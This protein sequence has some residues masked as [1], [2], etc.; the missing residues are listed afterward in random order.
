CQ[1]RRGAH[2]QLLGHAHFVEAVGIFLCED[3][4]VRIFGEVGAQADNARLGFGYPCQRMAERRRLHAHVLRKERR[5]KAGLALAGLGGATRFEPGQPHCGF[6]S[7]RASRASAHSCGATGRKWLISRC[8]RKGT[9]VPMRVSQMM[10]RGCGPANARAT[11]KAAVRVSM[12][13]PS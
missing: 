10:T 7:S 5:G 13:L 3:V 9:P 12:S 1:T 2:Q 6:P 8:W 11:S 4:Q